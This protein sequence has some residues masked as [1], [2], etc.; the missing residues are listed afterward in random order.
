MDT[1]EFVTELQNLCIEL[2]LE[3][4]Q[5]DC[6]EAGIAIAAVAKQIGNFGVRLCDLEKAKCVKR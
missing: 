4:K 3:A 5:T 1:V 6:P 2:I